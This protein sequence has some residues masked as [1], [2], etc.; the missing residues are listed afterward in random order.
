MMFYFRK[1]V[2]NIRFRSRRWTRGSP[3][4]PG[5]SL[6]YTRRRLL[7]LV[8]QADVQDNTPAPAPGRICRRCARHRRKENDKPNL[9]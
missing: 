8:Y 9:T 3:L 2:K 1:I 4:N 6:G 5:Q 7:V